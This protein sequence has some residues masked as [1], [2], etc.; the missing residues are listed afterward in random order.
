MTITADV[1]NNNGISTIGLGFFTAITA[2][3]GIILPPILKDRSERREI[4]AKLEELAKLTAETKNNT[5]PVSNG[6]AARM[7]R[8]L[9]L[10]ANNQDR[11]EEMLTEHFAWHL[12]EKENRNG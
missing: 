11:L 12:R 4:K 7:D 9:D 10:L 5:K 2:M 3:I 1:I 8:K 6:F